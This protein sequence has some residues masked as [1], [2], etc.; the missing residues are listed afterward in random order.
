MCVCVYHTHLQS[1]LS[2]IKARTAFNSENDTP[3]PTLSLA[4][5]PGASHSR[6]SGAVHSLTDIQDKEDTPL[7]KVRCLLKI[8]QNLR[9]F[10]SFISRPTSINPHPKT[11]SAAVQEGGSNGSKLP[12]YIQE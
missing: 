4:L 1:V 8:R 7:R 11:I 5:A 2:V 9:G 10:I 12:L 3:C 6:H